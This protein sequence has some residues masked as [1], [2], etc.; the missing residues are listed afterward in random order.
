MAII[1]N[2]NVNKSGEGFLIASLG[3]KTFD[4]L[5]GISKDDGTSSKRIIA[6]TRFLQ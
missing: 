4:V 2:V 1:I 5:L 3:N 6:S